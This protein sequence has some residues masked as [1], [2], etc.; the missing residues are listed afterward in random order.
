VPGLDGLLKSHGRGR[1][2]I[3]QHQPAAGRPLGGTKR[4]RSEGGGRR[5]ELGQGTMRGIEV[6]GTYR[7]LHQH[8]Q[9]AS[10]TEGIRLLGHAARDDRHG[11]FGAVLGQAEEREPATRRTTD[12]L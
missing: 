11:L 9:Q 10:A 8:R 12:R 6:S 4:S 5:L 3:G 1:V 2:T 7:D